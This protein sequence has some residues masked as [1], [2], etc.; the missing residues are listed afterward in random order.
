MSKRYI[1][2]AQYLPEEQVGQSFILIF[3]DLFIN[4]CNVFYYD[5]YKPITI[6]NE[7]I[8]SV[9]SYHLVAC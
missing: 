9:G 7:L 1:A 8:T 3:T 4:T 5:I 6:N 2:S